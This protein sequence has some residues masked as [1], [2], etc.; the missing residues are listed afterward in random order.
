MANK[1]K[2]RYNG[3]W[4][5]EEGK[6]LPPIPDGIL[7]VIRFKNPIGGSVIWED[8]VKGKIEIAKAMILEGDSIPKIARITGLSI[9]DIQKI[10]S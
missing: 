10:K 4:R 3:L 7:P 9:K 2:P 1:E 5:P 6:V 8:A